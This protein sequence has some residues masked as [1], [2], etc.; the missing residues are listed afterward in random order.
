M[1]QNFKNFRLTRLFKQ[2]DSKF[3]LS[4]G[5]KFGAI[6]LLSALFIYYLFW[7]LISVNNIYMESKVFDLSS[8]LRDT[9]LL[10]S[11]KYLYSYLPEIF[12]FFILIFFSGVYVGK[13]LLRPFEL[14]SRYSLAKL[15]GD[16]DLVYNPDIFSEYKLLTRISEFFFSYIE[17]CLKTN[18]LKP[19][20]IPSQFTQIHG[21]SFERVFFF[22]FF[23]LIIFLAAITGSFIGFISIEIQNSIIDLILNTVPSKD[24][25]MGY[26]INNQRYIFESLVYASSLI[27][28]VGYFALSFHLYNKISGAIFGF[29]ATMRSFMKGNFGARVHLI[30]FAHIRPHGRAFNKFLDHVERECVIDNN[31]RD[32]KTN[33]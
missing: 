31:N 18:R 33:I 17:E 3:L 10:N 7:I 2:D 24:I 22:H 32:Q 4:C 9:L 1:R 20:S 21:P 30:G 29:F 27:I 8:E 25:S 12:M 23:V 5:F 28:A 19:S 6:Y 13:V 15:E 26:F 16:K 14:I 11:F